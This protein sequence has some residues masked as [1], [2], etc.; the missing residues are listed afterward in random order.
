MG[1]F[2]FFKKGKVDAIDA[3]Q[4][5]TDPKQLLKIAQKSTEEEKLAYQILVASNYQQSDVNFA[6]LHEAVNSLTNQNLIADIAKNNKYAGMR[7]AAVKKLTVQ[8]VLI[9]IAQNDSNIDVR[10]NAIGFVTDQSVLANIAKNDRQ[11]GARESAIYHIEDQEL[12]AYIALND[13]DNQNRYA[14]TSRITD[15]NILAKLANNKDEDVRERALQVIRCNNY[16][17]SVADTKS[18]MGNIGGEAKA[19]VEVKLNDGSVLSDNFGFGERYVTTEDQVEL[20][21]FAGSSSNEMDERIEAVQK[22]T[23]NDLLYKIATHYIEHSDS[24]ELGQ[25]ALKRITS[26]D[27]L[28]K[29]ALTSYAGAGIELIVELIDDRIILQKI[30]NSG[31]TIDVREK[32][33]EK[34]AKLIGK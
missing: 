20:F 28:L 11:S 21:N 30:A 27:L 22:M 18:D 3:A 33:K 16:Q 10:R 4:I 25:A 24:E 29:F 19:G 13:T 9:D 8:K 12:L 32:A 14:A 7:S 15:Q 31:A 6:I 1:L 17:S 5:I 23:D 34:L 26:K 2:D